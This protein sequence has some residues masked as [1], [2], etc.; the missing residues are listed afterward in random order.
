MRPGILIVANQ[1]A[2][3]SPRYHQVSAG[4]FWPYRHSLMTIVRAVWRIHVARLARSGAGHQVDFPPRPQNFE[5][6][7]RGIR[8]LMSGRNCFKQDST[9]TVQCQSKSDLE[10]FRGLLFETW[11]IVRVQTKKTGHAAE[12]DSNPT[13]LR[14]G[15]TARRRGGRPPRPCRR[16]PV[17]ENSRHHGGRG[18]CR[19]PLGLGREDRNHSLSSLATASTRSHHSPVTLP[20]RS[21]QRPNAVPR[22]LHSVLGG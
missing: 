19:D 4:V 12:Q 6:C 13:L 5:G 9:Q 17:R 2:F 10:G 16:F 7:W 20:A 15:T 1:S 22:S 11:E 3:R 14:H 8:L 18:R 21:V